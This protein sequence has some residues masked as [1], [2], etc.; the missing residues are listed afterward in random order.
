MTSV[1]PGPVNT[2][3]FEIAEK[4]GS[5]L[6][7]KKLTMV[8]PEEVVAKALR[9]SYYKRCMSVYSLPILG[10]EMLAKYIPHGVIL[11]GMRAMKKLQDTEL[12]EIIPQMIR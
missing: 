5:T 3:F 4:N 1:C 12:L 10:F 11:R 2:P 9:D 6:S 7:I 8:E